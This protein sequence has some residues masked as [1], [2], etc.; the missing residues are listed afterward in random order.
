VRID[1]KEWQYWLKED[2]RF[3][4]DRKVLANKK[5]EHYEIQQ[6]LST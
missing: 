5:Q 1:H 4:G 2:Y 3:G 6:I